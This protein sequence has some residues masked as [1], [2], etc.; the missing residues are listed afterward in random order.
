[1]TDNALPDFFVIG[2]P[3]A[4]TTAL[5]AALAQHP[6]LYLSPVK[7]PK[8]FLCNGSRPRR[9]DHRGPGD[10]HSRR[11]WVWRRDRYEHLFAAAAGAVPRGESTPFYLY[12]R[13]AHE[14]LH[15]AVPHARLVAVLRDPVDRAYSNWMHLRSDGLEPEADFL[16]ALDAEP[17]RVRRGWAPFWHYRGM[18]LYGEQL[19][20]LFRLFPREQV[21]VLRYRELVDTPAQA[22]AAVY[23]FLGVDV[24]AQAAV[25]ARPENVKPFV[26]SGTRND[27]LR[28][29]V[30]A[31]AWT[32]QWLPPQAW[33][34]A[35]G[36]VV[37]ALHAGGSARPPLD[38]E[39]R[40]RAVALFADDIALLG[41]VLDRSFDDWLG[42]Q[43]RGAFVTRQ[44]RGA[45]G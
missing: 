45:S 44:E 10:A 32:G 2:A 26:P 13:D 23:A 34:R 5:H 27:L 25:Q 22:L 21:H 31:G 18:G 24:P 41:Q 3:K 29:F 20:D 28:R 43:G 39:Q 14:A 8:F 4:G 7:E 38:T 9:R 35:S 40:R 6:G 19:L 33:R 15:A 16:R 1:M 17:Q 11:E 30:R 37:R 36:G 12:R 42:D